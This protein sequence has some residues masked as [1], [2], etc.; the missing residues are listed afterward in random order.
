M[1]YEFHYIQ[2]KD[3]VRL[4][5]IHKLERPLDQGTVAEIC[6]SLDISRQTFYNYF[7]SKTQM[8]HW[9]LTFLSQFYLASIGRSYTWREGLR[10]TLQLCRHEQ[11]SLTRCLP[12]SKSGASAIKSLYDLQLFWIRL[13]VDQIKQVLGGR[14]V[15]DGTIAL[16]H[17]AEVYVAAEASLLYGWIAEDM[18]VSGEEV[19]DFIAGCVP[20]MLYQELSL[21]VCVHV[22]R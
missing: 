15:A 11:A 12:R 19:A 21:Q 1:N 18:A 9:Y 3:A 16:V 20:P 17:Y 22:K 14:D 6:G 7:A 5:M 10:K 8:V 13:R 4:D 2:G